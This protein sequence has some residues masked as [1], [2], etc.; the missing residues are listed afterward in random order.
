[1]RTRL[2]IALLLFLTTSAWSNGGESQGPYMLIYK[3]ESFN[4]CSYN[5]V[6][7]GSTGATLVPITNGGQSG[8]TTG[9][10]YLSS[11]CKEVKI[12]YFPTLEKALSRLN[13]NG[14]PTTFNGYRDQP[15]P[16]IGKDDLI[17]LFKARRIDLQLQET[18]QKTHVSTQVYVDKEVPMTEWDVKP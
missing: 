15:N 12:E 1:M 10:M 6:L 13:D 4:G 9:G 2:L 11:A 17:G 18:G 8:G 7:T 3:G 5:G 16:S 14:T